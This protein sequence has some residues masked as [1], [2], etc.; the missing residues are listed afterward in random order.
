MKTIGTLISTALLLLFFTAQAQAQNSTTAGT[1]QIQ[2]KD[3]S[4]VAVNG[5]NFV[6]KDNNGICD[7]RGATKGKGANF[8]DKDGDGKCD[9]LATRKGS[10]KGA[11]F[12]DKDGDGKCDNRANVGKGKA[13]K[14]SYGKGNKQ[15][16]GNGCC[17]RGPGYGQQQKTQSN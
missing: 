10:G 9:N 11:N 15:G 3:K 6:D 13:N 17:G 4:T 7:N 8:V 1:K 14:G 12:V 5:R 2:Q 16:K